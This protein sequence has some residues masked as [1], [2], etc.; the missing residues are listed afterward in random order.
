M[1]H[2]GLR[3]A[4]WA[5]L[6]YNL[7]VIM[8]GAFVRATGSGAGCGSHWPLCN[9]QVIPR[10]PEL[11][12]IIEFTH[13]ATSGIVLLAV[14]WIVWAVCKRFPKGHETR[15]Y[16][17]ASLWLTVVEALIGAGLVLYEL[18]DQDK[19]NARL[20]SIT[21]HL[22]NT[23]LL[24]GALTLFIR[25]LYAPGRV[26][27]KPRAR[28]HWPWFSVGVLLLAAG[29]TGAI[30][31]RGNTL[32]PADSLAEGI[33]KDFL[34][35]SHLA[36]RVRVLHPLFAVAAAVL[37]FAFGARR[38]AQGG[39][40]AKAARILV[41]VTAINV[42]MGLAN[43]L[44]LAPVPLQLLHLFVADLIWIAWVWIYADSTSARD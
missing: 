23:F 20:V 5:L 26:T 4:A 41:G 30:A 34:P 38:I 43:L 13:R 32:F 28:A 6:V 16:A 17:W 18:V 3:R 21:L 10:A 42:A 37:I 36:L 33:R 8:F 40:G 44:L 12:T 7:F 29:V 9:G 19:S 22:A 14:I 1:A 25:S 24:L 2:L 15:T 31:A 35:E 11:E 27:L 39:S